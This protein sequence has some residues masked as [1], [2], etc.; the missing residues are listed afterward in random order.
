MPLNELAWEL[1]RGYSTPVF[2]TTFLYRKD[3]QTMPRT[4]S[5]RLSVT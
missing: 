1:L 2:V 4:C 3:L 5:M